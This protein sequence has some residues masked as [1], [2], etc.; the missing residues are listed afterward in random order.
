MH[1]YQLFAWFNQE[2]SELSD[3]IVLS[4]KSS[5]RFNQEIYDKLTKEYP[6][7]QQ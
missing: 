7:T 3:I 4:D 2:T 5:P 1:R 6:N